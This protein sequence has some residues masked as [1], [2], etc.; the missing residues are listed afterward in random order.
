M[1]PAGTPVLMAILTRRP[2]KSSLPSLQVSSFAGGCCS[3]SEGQGA[4]RRASWTC[5]AQPMASMGSWKATMK[6][7]P[8]VRTCISTIANLWFVWYDDCCMRAVV[9]MLTAC[10]ACI[11]AYAAA[12]RCNNCSSCYAKIAA[13]GAV[14]RREGLAI[15][16]PFLILYLRHSWAVQQAQGSQHSRAVWSETPEV[17]PSTGVHNCSQGYNRCSQGNCRVHVQFQIVTTTVI[18]PTN[19]RLY[20]KA[21]VAVVTASL[22]QTASRTH[23]QTGQQPTS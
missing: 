3:S 11:T 4:S 12:T 1:M 23:N 19:R 16:Q 7:Y 6:A 17:S 13:Q 9:A 5:R 2:R 20:N 14:S 21:N 18:L 15:S 8:S 22:S 10:Q